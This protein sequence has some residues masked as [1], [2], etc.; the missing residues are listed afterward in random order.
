MLGLPE[1]ESLSKLIKYIKTTDKDLMSVC[2]GPA[3]FLCVKDE[4]HPYAGYE[5]ACFPDAVDKQTPMFGYLPGVQT[6]YF[7]EK[8]IDRGMKIINKN[9][10][11]TVANDRKLL[12]GASPKACQELGVLAAQDLLKDYA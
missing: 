3:A 1:D 4:P 6:W 9:P 10:D 5:V 11:G 2:H 7:G 8:L 12:T